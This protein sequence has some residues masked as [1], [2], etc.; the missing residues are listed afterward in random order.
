MRASA[1]A[2]LAAALLV[3]GAAAAIPIP[4]CSLNGELS[5]GACVCDPGWSGAAC[6]ILDLAPAAPLTAATQ[7]YFHPS[8]GGAAGGGFISNSWGVSVARDDANASLWHGFMTEM[9]GNCSLSSWTTASHILHL[10]APSPAGP[11]AVEGVALHKF[12]HNP[13]VVRAADGAWLLFHIGS[14]SPPACEAEVCPGPHSPAC[15]GHQGTSVARAA[16]PYGPWER[17]PYVLSDNETN[18]SALVLADGSLAVT[19]RRWE[20]G[21]PIYTAADWRGPYTAAPRAPVVLVRAG[22]PAAD[23]YSPF[24]E[25]PFLFQDSRGGF[26]MLTHRQPNGTYCPQGRNPTDCDCA[27]GHMYAQALAGPWFVDLALVYNCTLAVAGEGGAPL[28]LIARQRPTL[29]LPSRGRGQPACPVLFTGAS[30]AATQYAASFTM[31]Q[32]VSC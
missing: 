6:H 24:D 29:L 7:T 3:A 21:V 20:G 13:Q 22:A 17:A 12:A 19:A 31:A 23:A 14:P 5:G 26:H 2:C 28:Q 30:S 18:P 11:W 10:T 15:N 16:S 25:D 9:A 4:P 27:G 32:N 1:S 8:N